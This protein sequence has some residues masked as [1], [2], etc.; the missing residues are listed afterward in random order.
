[1]EAIESFKIMM[2]QKQV[3]LDRVVQEL[4]DTRASA[5]REQKLVMSAWYNSFM[6]FPKQEHK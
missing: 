6:G 1:M 2:Q 4:Y 5:K 3:E